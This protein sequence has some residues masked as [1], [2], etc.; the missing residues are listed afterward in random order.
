MI[1]N[2]GLFEVNGLASKI[3]RIPA[4]ILCYWLGESEIRQK[5]LLVEAH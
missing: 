2:F 3:M 5:S 1:V 4:C